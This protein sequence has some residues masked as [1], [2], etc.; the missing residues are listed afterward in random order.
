MVFLCVSGFLKVVAAMFILYSAVSLSN[1][2]RRLDWEKSRNASSSHIRSSL[3]R[4]LRAA[5]NVHRV[6]RAMGD[7]LVF[8]SV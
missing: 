2:S 8:S 7:Y 3:L 4:A 1:K 5:V 6:G